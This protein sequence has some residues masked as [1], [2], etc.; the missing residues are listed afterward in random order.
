MELVR[1]SAQP[2]TFSFG[3]NG[4]IAQRLI[5]PDTYTI[6]LTCPGKTLKIADP[7]ELSVRD[8]PR[9]GR[10][11]GTPALGERHIVETAA[12]LKEI[13]AAYSHT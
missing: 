1:E 3:F 11:R 8:F 12:L 4:R 5:D 6:H 13:Y 2:R 7:L 10:L 9:C